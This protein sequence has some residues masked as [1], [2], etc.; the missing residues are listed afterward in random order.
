MIG[1][2]GYLLVLFQFFLFLNYELLSV[3]GAMVAGL[4]ELSLMVWLLVK[5]A[6][7]PENKN[8]ME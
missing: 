4:A 1:S 5:G 3:P 2:F 7:T 8:N 6:K